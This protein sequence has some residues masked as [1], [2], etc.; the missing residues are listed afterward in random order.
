M[1][2][3]IKIMILISALRRAWFWL[4]IWLMYYLLFTDYAGVGIIE[5][6][7]ISTGFLLEIPTGA[8]ADLIGKKKTII[9]AAFCSLMG[10]LIMAMAC[11]FS[12]L[13]VSVFFL[14]TGVALFSGTTDALIYDSLKQIKKEKN[15]DT[16][17]SQIGIVTLLV[18]AI[19][20]IVGGFL[21]RYNPRLPFWGTS[22]TMALAFFLTFFLKEPN[23]D[24]VKFSL[25][26]Y[27]RQTREGF[28]ELFAKQYS[29][30]W[31][32]K[33]L[34]LSSFVVILDE[35]LEPALALDYG[36]DERS[37]GVLYAALPFVGVIGNYFYPKLKTKL[38]EHALW[39]SMLLLT[40]FSVGLSPLYG[41]VFGGIT[42]LARSLFYPFIEIITSKTINRQVESK[43][44]ATTLSTFSMFKSLPYL[45]TAYFIGKLMDLHTPSNIALALSI[46]FLIISG[47]V[48]I[49]TKRSNQ[50]DT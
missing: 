36:F 45:V 28:R 35:V 9:L 24:T 26:T 44:R 15:F 16:V 3:N 34:V 39:V 47:I 49:V 42:L 33:L 38:T 32:I 12:Q 6:V 48:S 43:Y 31:V 41:I 18:M 23:I 11:N 37:L 5:T 4:G 22:I 14:G 13:L 40:I 7:V 17:L 30:N 29:K 1:R 20:S 46:V 50:L 21:Y 19:A 10:N 8:F 27:L 25:H 2:N